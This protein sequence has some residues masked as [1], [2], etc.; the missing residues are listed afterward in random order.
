MEQTRERQR[1]E[2]WA[3]IRALRESGW[4]WSERTA[5]LLLGPGGLRAWYDPAACELRFPPETVAL[6]RRLWNEAEEAA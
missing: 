3:D 6:M 4:L 2:V 1:A 5:N